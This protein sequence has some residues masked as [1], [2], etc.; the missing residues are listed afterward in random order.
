MNKNITSIRGMNDCFTPDI[1]FWQKIEN[2]CKQILTNYGFSEIRTPIIEQT[3]LFS[4]AIG[5]V[6]DV[7]KKEM[8]TFND[9][10]GNSLTLRPENTTGCVR[11]GIE[12]GFLYKKRQQR[13]WYLGPMFRY[14]RPQKGRYRQFYQLGAEV[15]GFIGPDIDAELINITARLFRELG[16]IKYISLEINSIGSLSSRE[17][18][19]RVLMDFLHQY[20]NELDQDSLHQLLANPLRILDTKNPKIQE[21]LIDAPLLADY[22]D[23]ESKYHFINLCKLL[24]ATNIKYRINHRLVRGL[25][26][27]NRTVF[28]WITDILGAQNTVCAGGRYDNLVE[29][30]GGKATPAIGFAIGIDR[31]VLLIKQ[32]NPYFIDEYN[33]VDVY[34]ITSGKVSRQS[35]LV[36]AEIIRDHLPYFTIMTH[37]GGGN[38]KKQ[39]SH[40]DKYQAKIVLILG[41][42][43]YKS[44]EITIKDLRTGKQEKITQ[45][46]IIVRL[47]ELLC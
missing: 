24:D 3:S 21:I 16:I 13:L 22:I 32:I 7:V 38:L 45:Q 18:Y 30:L 25:D 12:H 42:N 43:E 20:E 6:T 23:S 35:M 37:Y 11:S 10:S 28:E 1:K 44:G 41:E 47:N 2:K 4:R 39:L 40:A 17:K 46:N 26:Y 5:K 36:L 27:Y 15:F 29:Q 8:Y 14:D 31:M 19:C 33:I 34:L 9:R